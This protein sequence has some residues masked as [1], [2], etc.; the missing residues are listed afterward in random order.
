MQMNTFP[1]KS[2][3]L[4]LEATSKEWLWDHKDEYVINGS[5]LSQSATHNA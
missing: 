5:I 2:R 4:L 1:P 3:Y